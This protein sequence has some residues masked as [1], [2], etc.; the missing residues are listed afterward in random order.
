MKT[1]P[2]SSYSRLT[3]QIPARSPKEPPKPTRGQKAL[4]LVLFTVFG[5]TIALAGVALYAT[6]RAEH[7]RVPNVFDAG[8]AADRINV[9]IIGASLK[10]GDPAAGSNIRT[11]SLM[12]LSVQ[13]STGRAALMSIPVDLWVKVGRYGERPLRAA[14]TVG[15][16]SGYPGAGAG[17][18]V[19]TVS[20]I[21]GQPIHGYARLSI[22][23]LRRVV[24]AVG[25]V[26]VDVHRGVYDYRN[27]HRF[28]RGVHR[29][30]GLQA[31]HYAYARTVVGFAR[32]PFEFE[33]RRQEV[34]SAVIG[35]VAQADPRRLASVIGDL[36]A[37]NLTGEQ[38]SL[39]FGAV[40]RAQEPIRQ[41]SFEPYLDQVD[42]STVAY[43][44]ETLQPRDGDFATLRQIAGAVFETGLAHVN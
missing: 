18:T 10:T 14:Y 44:G 26:E 31:M 43:R 40:R 34:V 30:N 7:R 29:L 42:V 39:L 9:L 37:T 20:Q 35:R 33:R 28:T 8:L 32:S 21:I 11:E 5:L 1:D 4:E 24:D 2:D 38:I 36:A 12:L 22:G 41:V 23:D 25:G 19:D 17:L 15:D 13:P 16:A 3:A 6:N 27:D